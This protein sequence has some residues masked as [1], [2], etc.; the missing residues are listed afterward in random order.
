MKSIYVVEQGSYSD[1]SVVG[2][3]SSKDNATRI[4]AAINEGSDY[5][6][7]TVE[8]WPIDPA[9]KELNQGKKQFYIC[10]DIDGE[11]EII[12]EQ[13]LATY[14]LT[15][16][17]TVWKRTEAAAY[18]HKNISD[19]VHGVVWAKNEKGAVKIA[20]EKRGMFIAANKMKRHD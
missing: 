18:R 10:M 3:F 11:V 6:E 13:N 9:I 8:E 4:A 17:L 5:D 2:V 7:A 12:N 1:Y 16:N 20:N 15:T 19:A 14:G